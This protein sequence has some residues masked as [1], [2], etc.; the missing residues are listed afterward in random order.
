MQV[1]I[2]QG[3]AAFW[4]FD[5]GLLHSTS[6][7][8]A[9]GTGSYVRTVNECSV[10]N[11]P[12]VSSRVKPKF[13]YFVASVYDPLAWRKSRFLEDDLVNGRLVTPS[14]AR[15]SF[16]ITVPLPLNFADTSTVS[17][18]ISA[19]LIS[20]VSTW[21]TPCFA[22]RMSS[23]L[24][25]NCFAS[26]VASFLPLAWRSLP[27]KWSEDL[28]RQFQA[29]PLQWTLKVLRRYRIRITCF[30]INGYHRPILGY[31]PDLS[32]FL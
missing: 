26:L 20:L 15:N 16:S 29:L 6:P 8:L 14:N 32:I 25:N 9:G 11:I 12:S 24:W 19:R 18:D 30:S 3:S 21:Y 10:M 31:V 4:Q 23:A 7:F 13:G 1:K 27:V 2:C 22:V 28:H 5:N 17:S